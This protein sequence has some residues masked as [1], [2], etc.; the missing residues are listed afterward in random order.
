LKGDEAMG[1]FIAG[2]VVGVTLAVAVDSMETKL[3]LA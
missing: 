3:V 2:F 1:W